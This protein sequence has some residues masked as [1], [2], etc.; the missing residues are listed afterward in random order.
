VVAR[1]LFAYRPSRR[2]DRALL[3]AADLADERGAHLT[4][5]APVIDSER[6]RRC[7][8]LQGQRWT[9]LLRESAADDLDH[10]RR[11]LAGRSTAVTYALA[12]G[13]DF[14]DIVED[15]ARDHGC[16]LTVASPEASVAIG[17]PR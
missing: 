1:V 8:G 3:A 9:A 14:D 11:A 12:D 10:A 17:T 13:S 4:V 15:F 16:E 2:A 6:G 5:L 7:C